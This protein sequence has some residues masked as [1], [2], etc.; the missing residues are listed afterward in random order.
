MVSNGHQTQIHIVHRKF[1]EAKGIVPYVPTP[2]QYY[3]KSISNS[4]P[5]TIY[6]VML[7][8]VEIH[9][10]PLVNEFTCSPSYSIKPFINTIIIVVVTCTSSIH[11][12]HNYANSNITLCKYKHISLS[13]SFYAMLP[14]HPVS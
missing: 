10:Q 11:P 7:F 2:S 8:T 1:K 5:P 13:L 12:Q 9:L 14:S 3:C 4:P 6:R